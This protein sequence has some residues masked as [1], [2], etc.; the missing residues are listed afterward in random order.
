[1]V[2]LQLKL[3]A[4]WLY[5]RKMGGSRW[6]EVEMKRL[7]LASA[8]F[9]LIFAASMGTQEPEPQLQQQPA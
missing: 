5:P 4:K 2:L 3:A 9:P 8:T 7:L 1:M 6:Q